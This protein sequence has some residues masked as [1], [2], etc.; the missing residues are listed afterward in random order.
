VVSITG[1]FQ[2]DLEHIWSISF[3]TSSKALPCTESEIHQQLTA[4][5]RYWKWQG[6]T[7]YDKT[8]KDT[9]NLT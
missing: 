6:F 4:N 2:K 3:S 8:N 9:Q 1:N 5:P 7:G